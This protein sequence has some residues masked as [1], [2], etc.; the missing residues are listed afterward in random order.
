MCGAGVC[1]CLSACGEG[2]GG[3]GQGG[4]GLPDGHTYTHWGRDIHDPL[5]KSVWGCS[6]GCVCQVVCLA[7]N[8][9]TPR[10]LNFVNIVV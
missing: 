6:D 5:G 3:A 9:Q 10:L 4:A 8:Q 2:Q 1:L 7:V